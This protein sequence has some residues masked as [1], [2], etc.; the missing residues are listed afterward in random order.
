MKKGSIVIIVLTLVICGFSCG[1]FLGRNVG[2]SPISV[3]AVPTAAPGSNQ[4]TGTEPTAPTAL[5]PI[6]INTATAEEFATLSGIGQTLAQRIVDYRNANG[7]FQ[8]LA[9]LLNVEGI[10]EKKLE[11]ILDYITIGGQP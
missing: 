7:P 9:D 8:S 5:S 3:S 6:D 11:S 2:R 10:G 1:F 4:S